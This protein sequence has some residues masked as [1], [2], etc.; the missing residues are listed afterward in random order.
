[1]Y[2]GLIERN[3]DNLAYYEQ[4]EKCL[5]ICECTGGGGGSI[6]CCCGYIGIT[7]GLG[8]GGIVRTVCACLAATPEDRLSFY[9]AMLKQYPRS[10]LV[11]R[12]RL[13]IATGEL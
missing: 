12:K 3:P 5:N 6:V 10:H 9:D 4:L 11:K 13:I 8:G 2:R 7:V 1:M